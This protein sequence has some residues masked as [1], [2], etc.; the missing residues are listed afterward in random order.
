MKIANIVPNTNT[1][2]PEHFNVVSSIDDIIPDLPTLIVG[3]DL[4]KK[5]FENFDILER[6]ISKNIYWTVKKTEDRDKYEDNIAWF[7]YMVYNNLIKDIKYIIIDPIQQNKKTIKKI[8]N[9]IYSLNNIISYEKN[10]MIYIYDEN[11]IFGVD[12]NIL[13]YIGI[14]TKRVKEKIKDVSKIY[15]YN[16]QIID[17]YKDYIQYLDNNIKYIPAIYLAI[18][19]KISNKLNFFNYV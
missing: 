18:N 12:L 15:L 7:Q 10:N 13:Q 11:L 2:L 14:N 4:T 3:Y 19:D 17:E 6:K 8:I 1:T 5:L 16:K 9:K